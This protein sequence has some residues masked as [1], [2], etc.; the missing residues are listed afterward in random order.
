MPSWKG[1]YAQKHGLAF[2][3]QLPESTE[4]HAIPEPFR[5]DKEDKNPKPFQESQSVRTACSNLRHV[6]CTNVKKRADHMPR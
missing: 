2:T 6:P 3:L 5:R 4:F 1:D